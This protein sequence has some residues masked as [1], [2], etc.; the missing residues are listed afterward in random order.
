MSERSK[1]ILGHDVKLEETEL[2]VDLE[3]SPSGD[4][5]IVR[6]ELNLGQA[7][8]HRLRTGIGELLDIGH[9]D[10][11][12]HLYDLIGEPNNEATRER[13]K[14]IVWDALQRDPRIKQIVNISVTSQPYRMDIVDIDITVIAI[15]RKVPLNIVLP[16]HLEVA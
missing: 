16:F 11:G 5:Q 6:D 2:G 13:A 1:P 12:S 8:V 10:Y 3:V 9:S 7:I 4:L 15:G 14:A